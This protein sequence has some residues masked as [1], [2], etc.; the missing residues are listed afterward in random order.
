MNVCI[1]TACIDQYSDILFRR[2]P[3]S[4]VSK[5]RIHSIT[6]MNNASVSIPQISF[7]Y[8]TKF[9]ELPYFIVSISLDVPV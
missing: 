5:P 7:T 2:Y 6:K 3:P 4:A 9:Y 8:G 1:W